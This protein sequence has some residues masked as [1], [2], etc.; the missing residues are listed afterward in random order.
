M[1]PGPDGNDRQYVPTL[2]PDHVDQIRRWHERAYAEGST[3]GA[4]EQTFD[5]LG[6]SIVVPPGVMPI[7]PMSHLLG[8]SV[9]AEVRDGD[10]V[11]DMGT[12]SGVNAI[13]AAGRGA[14][15]LAVDVNP[16]ALDAAQ[17]NAERNGVAARV[18]VRYS[19]V[20]SDVDEVSDLIVFDPPF[21]WFRPRSLLESAMTDEGYQA[22]TTFFQQAR[23]HL[24]SRGRM[25]IFF[26]TSGDLGYLERLLASRFLCRRRGSR[27]LD[28]RRLG[29][30]LC[31]LSGAVGPRGCAGTVRLGRCGGPVDDW[32]QSLR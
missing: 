17:A 8:E 26:G 15:V 27:R 31:H 2:S 4:A 25:L 21:R 24:T 5:Y 14:R 6:I 20:F 18:E 12:G 32:Y 7:T 1:T 28:Q 23:Q 13:L 16:Q 10:R 29:C 19:D 22:M 30:R 3:E 11:L 9:L